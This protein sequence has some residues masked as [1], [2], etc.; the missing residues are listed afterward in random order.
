M[1]INQEKEEFDEQYGICPITLDYMK[2]PVKC[3]SGNYYEKSAIITWIKK[4]GTDPLTREHLTVDM[5]IEDE[6]YKKK[7]L[8]IGKN[9]IN[10]H[11]LILQNILSFLI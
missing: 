7:L 11:K 6:E 5:L 8:N 10:N 9:L 3:P 2:N 1:K 4:N